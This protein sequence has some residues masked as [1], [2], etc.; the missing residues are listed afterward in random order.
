MNAQKFYEECASLLET[1]HEGEAFT[2]YRRTR[3]NNRRPGRGRFPGRGIIRVF[4][5]TV[6]IA[7]LTPRLNVI[8]ETL[9]AALDL[10]REEIRK[11][12]C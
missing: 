4:G 9:P 7:L 5:D 3:W 6:H 11:Q 2:L 10:L 12:N 8:V 1:T